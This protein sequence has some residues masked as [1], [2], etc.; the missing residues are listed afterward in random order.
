MKDITN[1][2]VFGDVEGE[3]LPLDRC[4]CGQLFAYWQAVLHS[5]KLDPFVCDKCGRRMVFSNKI[6]IWELDDEDIEKAKE[7]WKREWGK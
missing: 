2:I 7:E 1:Q 5:E 3:A 6:T 4:A